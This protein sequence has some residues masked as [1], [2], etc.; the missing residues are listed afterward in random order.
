M[1]SA[2][3]GQDEISDRGLTGK[4]THPSQSVDVNPR[5]AAVQTYQVSKAL[6][7]KRG[8]MLKSII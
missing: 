6:S 2:G 8:E 1:H 7:A 5:A 4:L 3:R